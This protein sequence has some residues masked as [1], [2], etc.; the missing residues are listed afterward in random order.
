MH[1][2]RIK[3]RRFY[4]RTAAGQ[5][6]YR[7]T[8][9]MSGQ[10]RVRRSTPKSI[11]T[12]RNQVSGDVPHNEIAGRLH[13]ICHKP[14]LSREDLDLPPVL[15]ACAFRVHIRIV[16]QRQVHNATLMR[17]HRLQ[18]HGLVRLAHLTRD[19]QRQRAK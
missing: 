3:R 15:F 6:S 16:A 7:Q 4:F 13:E 5:H 9:P 12:A 11:V 19:A 18:G 10:R 8:E 17:R 14:A 2:Q 1:N